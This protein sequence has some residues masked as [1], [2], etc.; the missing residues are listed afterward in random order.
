MRPGESFGV[1]GVITR[2]TGFVSEAATRGEPF[3]VVRRPGDRVLAGS[4]CHDALFT[5]EAT[6]AGAHRQIDRLLEAVEAAKA[7]PLSMQSRADRL[8]VIFL[9]VLLLAAGGTFAYWAS[10][11][12]W[13]VGL[14]RAMSVL[15]VACPCALGL[16]TPI[17]L[18]SA[19]GRLAERGIVVQS[20]DV[21]ERLATADR[22]AF[23]K[24]GTLTEDRYALADLVTFTS[25]EARRELL[26]W[27][28]AV[29][30]KSD[31]PVAK[32]FADLGGDAPVEIASFQVFPGFGVEARIRTADG[33]RGLRIGRTEWFDDQSPSIAE[34]ESHLLADDGHR[35]AFAV[36]GELAGLAVLTER[37]RETARDTLASLERM[38]I[39]VEVLTGDRTERA[40]ALDLPNPQGDMLPEQK[41]DIIAGI[42]ARGGHP[43]MVGDGINDA[44]ALKAAHVGLALAGGTDIA[45]GAAD[46]VLYAPDLR[47]L[48]WAIALSQEAVRV[49]NRNINRAVCYNLIGIALAACGMLHP[50]AAA[51]LMVASSLLVAWSSVRIGVPADFEH[52][53]IDGASTAANTSFTLNLR[54]LLHALAFLG[55]GWLAVRMLDLTGTPAAIA[56]VGF[57]FAGVGLTW[58]WSKRADIGL[59]ADMAFGMLSIGNFGMLLGWWADNGF[60]PIDAGCECLEALRSGVFKPW[61]TVAMLLFANAAMLWATRRPHPN[62]ND[63]RTAMF[64]GGNL[65]MVAGMA[66]GGWVAGWLVGPSAIAG[67]AGMTA[68]MV[69]G[70]VAG[71]HLA[72]RL[73]G[74]IRS[75]G[76][77]PSWLRAGRA[78]RDCQIG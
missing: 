73:A 65:G 48:P 38:G 34:L 61:M 58:L 71:T 70:M 78:E 52:C 72:Q 33:E 66:G 16:A 45:L 49:V 47:A 14:F 44:A 17:V 9:P 7:K 27:L 56:V 18:W 36:D 30:G 74:L 40:A 4:V 68:G 8:T 11:E 25:G 2:G 69:A 42:V 12:S 23:D 63:H 62:I 43:V 75:L 28:A 1:D 41:A 32:P 21:V 46:A 3:A 26:G 50:I 15:L 29:E 35:I 60:K 19:L 20:G 64:T 55:Q 51:L 24:T 59:D 13:Q 54:V 57:T 76:Q 22:V 37:L 67:F 6:A 5:V 31:H 77:I 39:P 53:R 10:V